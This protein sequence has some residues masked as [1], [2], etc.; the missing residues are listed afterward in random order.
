MFGNR[1]KWTRSERLRAVLDGRRH[2][3]QQVIEA[4]FISNGPLSAAEAETQLRDFVT[5]V[6]TSHGAN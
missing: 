6:V 3:G 5:D 4:I 2:L 1:S